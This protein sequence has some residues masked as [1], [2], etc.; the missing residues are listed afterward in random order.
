M[1]P[2][3]NSLDNKKGPESWG[4]PVPFML[5]VAGWMIGIWYVVKVVGRYG[6]GCSGTDILHHFTAW[7][8]TSTINIAV[9]GCT[10][11]SANLLSKLSV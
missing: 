9:Y 7:R 8:F 3:F 5:P 11:F 2:I 6:A 1:K 4:L 10:A